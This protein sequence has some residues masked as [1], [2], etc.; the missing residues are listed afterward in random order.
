[1]QALRME[2]RISWEAVA[3]ALIALLGWVYT[4]G[5]YHDH[6]QQQERSQKQIE[7]RLTALEQELM[8]LES[9]DVRGCTPCAARQED[10]ESVNGQ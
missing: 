8:R 10:H 5:Q 7:A 1:M 2:R 4:A 6:V 3:A 9:L